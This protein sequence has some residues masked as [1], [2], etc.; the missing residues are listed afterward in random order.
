MQIISQFAYVIQWHKVFA[1]N[2][3]TSDNRH[4]KVTKAPLD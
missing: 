1:E 3:R 2:S 4:K